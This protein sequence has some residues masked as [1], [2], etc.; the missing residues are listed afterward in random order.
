MKPNFKTTAVAIL[1]ALGVSACKS[2]D[3]E[4]SKPSTPTNNQAQQQAKAKAEQEA[5]AKA[6]RE[7]KAKAEQEAKAKAEQAAKAEQEAKAKEEAA[8]KAQEEANKAKA[9]KEKADAAA[10]QAA[11]AKAKAEQEARAKEEAARKA[12]E[13][14]EKAKADK[15]KADEIAKAEADKKAAEAK[16]KADAERKAAE[17]KARLEKERAE[18]AKRAEEERIKAAEREKLSAQEKARLEAEKL[19]KEKIENEKNAEKARVEKELAQIP[20]VGNKKWN[21]EIKINR[22][23][24]INSDMIETVSREI[25]VYDWIKYP[26]PY[27][28]ADYRSSPFWTTDKNVKINL[29][30]QTQKDIENGG[31]YLGKHEGTW[32]SPAVN[33]FVAT[34]EAKAAPSNNKALK[35]ASVDRKSKDINYMYINNPYSTYGVIFTNQHDQRLF[36]AAVDTDNYGKLYEKVNNTDELNYVDSLKGNVT[37]QGDV[38]AVVSR[39]IV[40]SNA[41]IQELPKVDG[42]VTLNA[43]FGDFAEENSVEGKLES[44]TIGTVNLLPSRPKT[45]TNF[46]GYL[47]QL[48]SNNRNKIRND[49]GSYYNGEFVGKEAQEVVGVVN[50]NSYNNHNNYDSSKGGYLADKDGKNPVVGYKAVFGAT[51][52][53]KA[54]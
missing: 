34:A 16:A 9:E 7:A 27:E 11:E 21:P 25:D 17:D 52:Q 13:A 3:P 40:G 54:E 5:K 8:R 33:G 41:S 35:G 49:W 32:S 28:S 50:I 30:E 4:V 14:E 1:V 2:N 37:Y 39:G 23:G 53:P 20:V 18:A 10:K 12:R 51:K 24:R 46:G 19:A 15:A 47:E 45:D 26:A 44:N 36:Y 43:Y 42:K 48:D 31:Q 38:V 29:N 6:E 22:D